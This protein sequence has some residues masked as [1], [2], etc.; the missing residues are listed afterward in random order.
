M[1]IEFCD[2][3]FQHYL[4]KSARSEREMQIISAEINKLLSKRVL[5]VTVHSDNEIISDIFLRDNK[6]GSHRMILKLKKL[7]MEA[8][9]AHFK[10]DTLHTITKLIG[11]DCFMVSID[12][13]DAYY[14]V[15]ISKEDRKYLW[16]LW[17]GTLFQFTCL[18]NSLSCTP[19]KFTKLLKPALSEFHLR[20]HIS[21][22]YIDDMNLQGWTYKECVYNVVDSVAR[23]VGVKPFTTTGISWVHTKLGLYD[24]SVNSGESHRSENGLSR[25]AYEP[26]PC[27]KGTS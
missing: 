15:P 14:S 9:K 18:P 2:K 22:A 20:G 23:K 25:S 12:L 1:S 11:K 19:R 5:E 4:L 24:N 7:N 10:M 17:Q 3:P 6:D 26:I 21:S 27:D 13:K 8:A 16:F